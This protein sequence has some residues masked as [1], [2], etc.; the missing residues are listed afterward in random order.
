MLRKLVDIHAQYEALGERVVGITIH[1][2]DRDRFEVSVT[3]AARTLFH[4]KL[5][6]SEQGVH[7]YGRE[8]DQ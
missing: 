4:V 1:E 8:E 7:E 6:V 2:Q 5:R 3:D